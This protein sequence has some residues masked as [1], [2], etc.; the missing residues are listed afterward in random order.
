MNVQNHPLPADHQAAASLTRKDYATTAM[1]LWES[2][3]ED[4]GQYPAVEAAHEQVGICAL[5]DRFVGL[6]EACET[7]FDHA[8]HAGYSSPFDFEFVPAFLRLLTNAADPDD[9]ADAPRL[10]ITEADYARAGRLMALRDRAISAKGCVEQ[11]FR[12]M[13]AEGRPATSGRPRASS[14]SSSLCRAASCPR[15][16]PCAIFC[17]SRA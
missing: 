7:I 14:A 8:V 9:A 5:R 4:P 12:A 13:G 1:I 16:M 17:A 6:V 11:T 2:Y 10:R 3:L 15:R